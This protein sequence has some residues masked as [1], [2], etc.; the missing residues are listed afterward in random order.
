M[1]E[2]SGFKL[3]TIKRF[4]TKLLLNKK[5][6]VAIILALGLLVRLYRIN[7]PLLDWHAWRQADTA[8]V[9]ARYVAEGIDL[10]KPKYHDLS[11][12]PSGL[13]NP[14]GYRMVEFPIINAVTASFLTVV[15]Q[16]DL[17]ITSRFISI[18]ASIATALSLFWLIKQIGSYKLALLSA[19]FFCFLPFSI[20]YGR[21]VL[22]EPHFLFFNTM[23]LASFST[24]LSTHN[25]SKK[26]MFWWISM[27][28]LAL[29]LLIKPFGLFLAPAYFGLI[30][31]HNK[32]ALTHLS[33]YLFALAACLP[34]I[35]W[36]KW[37]LHFP[38]GIPASNWLYN[39]QNIRFRPAWFRWL[40]WERLSKLIGG[41]IAPLIIAFNL[42]KKDKLLVFEISWWLSTL[43]FFSVIASGNIQH[44]YYQV[45]V[46][47]VYSFSLARGILLLQHWLEI[48][49][50][51]L[52]RITQKK[53]IQISTAIA[54]TL[55]LSM[56]LISWIKIHGYFNVNHW[57]YQ[58]A[59]QEANQLLPN[60]AK[61]IAPAQGDTM[62]LFQTKRYGWPIGGEVS[63]KILEGATHYIS[64]TN[65]SE[66][67]KIEKKYHALKKT[68]DFVIIDLS[69]E[70]TQD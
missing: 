51:K 12:I 13:S 11:N 42:I 10:L 6:Q 62:F 64:I 35:A 68:D 57:E 59:G 24:Y 14:E 44:D 53:A 29:T 48:K 70:R 26:T 32:Q 56:I 60:D 50:G 30:L 20:Y 7:N 61:V 45:F 3:P 21:V 17:T 8:S 9:T 67:I 18:L 31:F 27:L 2:S 5:A 28:S 22:P 16:L 41:Y 65:D 47:P 43:L 46:L 34:M 37:I 69:N 58:K 54:C 40:F 1:R 23:S 19:L 4:I 15:P 55:S 49:L 39:H 25:S 52:S 38:E 33:T 63:N 36:R 66:T